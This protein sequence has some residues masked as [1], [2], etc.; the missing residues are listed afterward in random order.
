M[1]K[2]TGK[3]RNRVCFTLFCSFPLICHNCHAILLL[4]SIHI[5]KGKVAAGKGK[6]TP[7]FS[8]CSQCHLTHTLTRLVDILL[9]VLS[10]IKVLL[11]GLIIFGCKAKQQVPVL[12]L[13][14]SALL[15][16][17]TIHS[18]LEPQVIRTYFW[19]W[20]SWLVPR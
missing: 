1:R 18:I 19:R 13:V 6:S 9:S 2:Y 15:L 20:F 8:A 5:L 4:L 11:A 14:F 7:F 10:P 3:N 16:L 17:F 12:A